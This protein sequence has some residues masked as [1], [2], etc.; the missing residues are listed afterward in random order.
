MRI[1][2]I[3]SGEDTLISAYSN[4]RRDG[5]VYGQARLLGKISAAKRADL[6]VIMSTLR[7]EVVDSY[8]AVNTARGYTSLEEG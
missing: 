5:V 3:S 6:A 2:V 8:N 4:N 1:K 7:S